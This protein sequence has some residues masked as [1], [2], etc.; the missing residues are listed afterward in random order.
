MRNEGYGRGHGPSEWSERGVPHRG[1]APGARP[2]RGYADP[3][4]FGGE[5]PRFAPDEEGRVPRPGPTRPDDWEDERAGH[6]GFRVPRREPSW[7]PRRVPE[8]ELRQGSWRSGERFD[9]NTA[10]RPHGPGGW[11]YGGLGYQ[12]GEH[13]GV[14]PRGYRRSD[15]RIREDVCDRLTDDPHT[16]PSDV[17]VGVEDGDVSLRGTVGDH[18]TKRRIEDIALT[19]GGVHDVI[20]EIRVR[21]PEPPVAREEVGAGRA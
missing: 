12:P 3:S 5:D 16:D 20:N 11:H 10:T 17:E 1:Y 18:R 15:E 19:V 6:P 7:D 14:A 9:P 4:R 13:R 8:E 2:P 21:R